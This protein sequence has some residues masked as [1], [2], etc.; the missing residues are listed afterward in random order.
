[1]LGDIRYSARIFRRS[2]AFSATVVLTLALGIGVTTAMFSV[3]NGVLLRP[4]PYSKPSALITGPST[5]AEIWSQWRRETAAFDDIA[6]YDFGRAPL[7]LAGDDTVRLRQAAVTSNMLSVLGVRPMVG[8]DFRPSDTEPGAEPVAMLTYCAWQLHFGGRLDVIDTIAPFEPVRRR[9]V[10]VLPADFLFP[11]RFIAS[12]GEVRTLTPLEVPARSGASYGV[13]ARLKSGVTLAQARA[14]TAGVVPHQTPGPAAAASVTTLADAILRRSRA[15]LLMLFGAVGCL[16]LIACANAGNLLFARGAEA[17]REFA[18]RLALGAGR[19]DLVRLVVIQSCT[20]AVAGGALGVLLTYASFD[21]LLSLLPP[22]LP[23]LSNVSV[24][25][26]V[27]GFAV[28]LSLISGTALGLFPACH[29]TRGELQSTLQTYERATLP[30]QR[31]RLIVLATEVALAFVLL[32]GAALFGNSLLRL[33]R[34]DLGFVPRNVLTLRVDML[35]SHYPTVK[36]QRAFL[37]AALERI[38]ALAG[39]TSVAAA[40]I[41]PVT[42]MK[43]GGS[44]LAIDAPS[45]GSADVEPRVI[46]PGYFETMG[47]EIVLGRPLDRQDSSGTSPV[48]AI[49]EALA[50]RLWPDSSPIGRRIRFENEVREVVGVVRDERDFAVDTEPEPQVYVPYAQSWLVPRRLV[51]RTHGEPGAFIADVRQELRA[52][53]SRVAVESLQPLATHVTASIAQPRFHALLLAIFGASGVLLASVGIAGT[54]AY[55]VSRRTREIGIR[56]ALGARQRDIVRAVMVPS[57]VAVGVGLSA[58]LA[59]TIVF[60][61][62]VRAFLYEVDAHD[63][64]TLSVVIVLMAG[65]ALAAAW[66]P[67]RRAQRIDPLVALRTE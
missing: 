7:L 6:L 67:A 37:D 17:R 24:D 40:E 31:L 32:S 62:L 26:W 18:V 11:M 64:L 2:P 1:M 59:A 30:A 66:F 63:P 5:S 35:E 16:L 58:G 20:L 41:L 8:R 33:L 53:D 51:I 29:L 55:A 56:I 28:A 23:R 22:Q 36:D 54:V 14:E 21:A 61:R 52:L 34:V 25:R 9:I 48:A 10:G 12:V 15:T 60:G 57:L 50:R 49:N 38:G 39:V 3:V 45:T 65:I 4:L 44:V 13:V 27:L 47:I 19:S 46:S 42:P 43:R